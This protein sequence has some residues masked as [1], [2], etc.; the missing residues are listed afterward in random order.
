MKVHNPSILSK[1]AKNSHNKCF[2]NISFYAIMW[3]ICNKLYPTLKPKRTTYG[4][5]ELWKK[6]TY[7]GPHDHIQCMS[8]NR[9]L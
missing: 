1:L 8:K 4:A 2:P 6:K 5:M 3:I 7:Q 9:I